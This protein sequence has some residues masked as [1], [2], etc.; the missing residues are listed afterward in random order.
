MLNSKKKT[1]DL[2]FIW[3]KRFVI[4]SYELLILLATG[5]IILGKF[6][7]DILH[8]WVEKNKQR[9]LHKKFVESTFTSTI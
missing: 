6:V 8:T 3:I 1:E 5:F 2:I 4:T 7:F 9:Q